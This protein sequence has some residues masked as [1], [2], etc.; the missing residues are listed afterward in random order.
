MIQNQESGL[1]R[2][3]RLV[4]WGVLILVGA[5]WAMWI[6]FRVFVTHVLPLILA[7]T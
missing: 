5:L 6:L 3:A 7:F 4:G 2:I 1:N